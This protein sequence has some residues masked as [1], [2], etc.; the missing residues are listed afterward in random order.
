MI[1]KVD[2]MLNSNSLND[3]VVPV[4]DGGVAQGV[5]M[6][7]NFKVSRDVSRLRGHDHANGRTTIVDEQVNRP[8]IVAEWGVR[9]NLTSG[10]R[11]D[12]NLCDESAVGHNCNP[13]DES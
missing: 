7:Y 1:N 10:V 5:L 8:V 6:W 3:L 2:E 12:S 11:H 9:T 13:N 4:F